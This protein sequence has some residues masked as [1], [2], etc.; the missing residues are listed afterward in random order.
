MSQMGQQYLGVYLEAIEN[1][2]TRTLVAAELLPSDGAGRD[3][4]V[5][6]QNIA[7]ITA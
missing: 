3:V 5:V 2:E 1:I 6:D 7:D 4:P